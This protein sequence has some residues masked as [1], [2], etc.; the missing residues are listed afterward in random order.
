MKTI[1]AAAFL[2]LPLL[3]AGCGDSGHSRPAPPV[4]PDPE[5]PEDFTYQATLTRTEYGI[6]HIVA[7]DWGSLGYGHGYAFAQDNYCML[8]T[9]I[10]RA[11]GQSL[12]FF[13]EAQGSEDTDFIFSLVN[14]NSEGQLRER[15]LS[16]QPEYILELVEGYAAG[17][18]RYLRETGVDNL[19]DTDPDCRGAHW[20]REIQAIDLWK[21]FRRIQLQGSTDQGIVRQAILDANGP[22]EGNAAGASAQ[23]TAEQMRQA[24]A[25]DDKGSNAIALGSHATQT[26]SGML[27]GNPHQPWYG[28]GS[29]YQ[30]HLTIPGEYDAMGAA[31]KGFPKV[32]I[33]FNRDLAWSH[34]V[35]VANRF[36]LFEL[37]LNPDN[38]LQYEV[39]GEFRDIVP[40]TVRIR[41]A[42]PDG[43]ME[44]REHTFYHWEHGLIVSLAATAAAIAPDFVDLFSGW[45]TARGTVYALRDANL[46]NLRGI[47][48]W[49]NIGKAANVGEFAEALKVIGNPLFHSLAADR[50][51]EAFYGEVSA[52]PHVTEAKMAD[53][54]TGINTV[55]RA[56]T[57][58]A[59]IVLDGDRS[60]CQWGVDSDAPED[61]GLFG[62]SSL[63]S[64]FTRNYAANSNDSYWLTDPAQP[65]EGFPSTM[66]FVGHEGRQQNL[67]TQINHAMVAERL[68]GADGFDPSPGFTLAS[69]QQLM[70]A[71][72]VWGAELV[73]DDVLEF[74]ATLDEAKV[75][76][77]RACAV[78]ADWDRRAEVDSRGT[79][80]FT[81]FWKAIS[82]GGSPFENAITDQ[83]LWREDFDPQRPLQTPRGFDI[84]AE[85]NAVRISTALATAVAA[86][87]AAGVPLAAPW[88]EVQ[89]L[90]RNG[91]DV[92]IHGGSGSMGVFGAISAGLDQGGY[93]NIRAGNSYIQTVTWDESECPLAEAII[94]T[95]QSI[96]P[97]SPNHGDQS[98]LYSRKAWVDMPY[99]ESDIE[100]A[101]SGETL[102]LRE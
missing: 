72:R 15:Y 95:S 87:D 81:E 14:N 65:L 33:G 82:V 59:I 69:L 50:H 66:G 19:P 1:V 74:C 97:E 67:R 23:L 18:N 47:E 64:F 31:L 88:G 20:V 36:T 3:L 98:E 4:T 62:F 102:E 78:L 80:V 29:F 56:L 76:A 26:G 6:P 57:N 94:T 79:Q 30:V 40:E 22:G 60:E 63:P 45:P 37:K 34:T 53:C 17:Y 91:V 7:E 11:S 35:S 55:V 70:Y 49:V 2:V 96:N 9:E 101:R 93:R 46:D 71:N 85:G 41:V 68:A 100:A 21:Y 86:L 38:P 24:F 28:V 51:G 99:C 52:I 89:V 61:S 73:L 75:D 84:A 13:G 58:A 90:P 27:L 32:A 8:I 92:P 39:D 77:L 43:S 48:M 42:R 12:E 5:A 83:S 10:I 16:Q 25:S 44:E 54:V